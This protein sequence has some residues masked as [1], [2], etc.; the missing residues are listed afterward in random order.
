MKTIGIIGYGEI[1][2]A[3][4]DIYLA[5]NYVPLIKDLDRDD[6]LG[7]VG[8][9][10][11][12]IPYT[13]DFVAQVS[14]Y[15][16]TLKPGL[17]IIHS[18]VPPGT[19]RLIGKNYP[20]VCHSPVRGV[21]PNLAEG[22]QTFVKVFGG[23]CAVPASQHFINDLGIEC[24]VYESSVSTEVAKLLDTSYYG[25]CIAWHDYAQKLCDAQGVDFDEAQT[26]YNMTYNNGYKELGK[27]NVVR[28]TLAP[29]QGSIGGH[30]IVPNAELLR[31]ELDSKLLEAVTDLK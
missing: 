14:E 30:C 31:T 3:L 12:C 10:N 19:T 9:L 15:I 27:R 22:I 20:A 18:T 21:H 6:G 26:H 7:G 13:Y 29:P 11:I 25:V 2:Q 4:D 8:V 23:V 17:T 16:D 1:G 28:P 24:E 5:N